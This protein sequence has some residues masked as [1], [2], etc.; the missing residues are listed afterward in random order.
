MATETALQPGKL[1][2][3]S[4]PVGGKMPMTV[5]PSMADTTG[6]DKVQAVN[7]NGRLMTTSL[8]LIQRS[9]V[10]ISLNVAI[11]RIHHVQR[12]YQLQKSTDAA[13]EFWKPGEKANNMSKEVL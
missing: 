9:F 12:G 4:A 8:Q 11:S 7:S 3:T 13:I 5:L 10:P 2:H 1:M 6:R